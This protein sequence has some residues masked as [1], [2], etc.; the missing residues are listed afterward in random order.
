MRTS[1]STRVEK[2]RSETQQP[3]SE[4]HAAA[5]NYSKGKVAMHGLKIALENPKGS[6]RSGVDADGKA[7]SSTMKADYGYILSTE[8]ND[9]DHVDVFIGP[10][11]EVEL[12]YIVNQTDPKS[13]RFDEHKVMLGYLSEK[14]AKQGY[15]DNYEPGWKGLGS[16]VP[17]TMVDFKDWLQNGDQTKRAAWYSGEDS[18]IDLPDLNTEQI[19]DAQ[20]FVDFPGCID[21]LVEK[22]AAAA[23]ELRQAVSSIYTRTDISV[24]WN[25]AQEK[26]ALYIRPE[27]NQ[28]ECD[29]CLDAITEKL[30]SDRV[31]RSPLTPTDLQ[32]WWVKIAYSPTLRRIA[33]T[34][35]FFP[36]KDIPG[37]G[38]RP[39]ASTI[40]SGLLGA[41][42]GYGGG[43]LLD[44]LTPES[45]RS[46]QGRMRNWGAVLGG[47]AGAGIGATPGF[48]NQHDGRDFNDSTLWSGFP[49]DGF[50]GDLVGNR[51]KAAVDQ[52]IEKLAYLSQI[53]GVAPS[54]G[55]PS[56][57][58]S[59]LIRTDELGNVLWG[60]KADPQTTAMTMGIVYGANQ[61]PDSR[62]R[63]GV[64]TPHQTG[65][66]GM[67][68]GA[69]GG[70]MK[71]YATGYVVGKGL[72]LL[73]GMPQSTQNKLKQ[74]GMALGIINSLVPRLFN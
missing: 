2:A 29:W 14:D 73:T 53:D 37:F 10:H 62:S 47:L 4:A 23:A 25:P 31:R 72:G 33:E 32:D 11:P 22:S 12:V 19:L 36:S 74:S 43:A 8:G 56:F 3:K 21:T 70:G 45:L 39:I 13:G 59:P 1:I 6:T 64:V 50:D 63:P 34:L 30:G 9:G 26:A 67:A 24:Y 46:E 17:I 66:L 27:F 55:G 68:M 40:A 42:I 16:I 35:Q 15:L 71:G 7:W 28:Q 48:I 65:L 18:L 38:G 44:K 52:Y 49:E 57:T 61:M 54:I 51:Y 60:S 41:G 58:Q 5:G 69:A 20:L